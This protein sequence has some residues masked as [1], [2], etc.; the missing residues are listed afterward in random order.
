M[1]DSVLYAVLAVG[2]LVFVL[3]L[4]LL[5]RSVRKEQSLEEIIDASINR[6]VAPYFRSVENGLERVERELRDFG[7]GIGTW[8]ALLSGEVLLNSGDGVLRTVAVDP[9]SGARLINAQ[10]EGDLYLMLRPRSGSS[11][12]ALQEGAAYRWDRN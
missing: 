4:V 1:S 8:Q 12:N 2:V 11:D 9:V 10:R 7:A 5:Q 6:S 3:Q